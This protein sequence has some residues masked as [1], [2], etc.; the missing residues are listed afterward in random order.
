MEA[1]TPK[2]LGDVNIPSTNWND[3]EDVKTL[4]EELKKR[5]AG[6][7]DLVNL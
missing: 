6:V 4:P 3:Y 7:V 5:V 1:L 2:R